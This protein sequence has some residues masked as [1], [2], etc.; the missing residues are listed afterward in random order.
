MSK[1]TTL[2]VEEFEITIYLLLIS[3]N[4][5]HIYS[6]VFITLKAVTGN[7]NDMATA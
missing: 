1:V 4:I 3:G 2:F 7:Y 6:Y 5:I